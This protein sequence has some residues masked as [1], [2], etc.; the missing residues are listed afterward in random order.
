MIKTTIKQEA[1]VRKLKTASAFLLFF[2]LFLSPSSA[3]RAFAAPPTAAEMERELRKENEL[4]K[5]GEQ[6]EK[7]PIPPIDMALVKGGCYKMGDFIGE[8][9]DDERPVH[10]VCLTDFYMQTTEV[11]QDL[12]EAVMGY[13]PSKYKDPKKPVTGVSWHGATAFIKKLNEEKKGFYRLPTEAEW[14]YA[15]RSGGKDDMWAG[16]RNEGQLDDYAWFGD[17]SDGDL[18]QVKQ[19]KPNALGL[20]DMSG[21][22]WEWTEDY[23]DFDYYQVS[24]RKDPYGPDMS[25]WKVIR[26]GSYVEDPYKIRTTF[27]YAVESP[28]RLRNVGFR[29]AE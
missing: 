5:E 28:S 3:N 14:E 7:K 8:G 23:F 15:A 19:K 27:R 12:F 17:N 9:D 29:L 18:H 16:T 11:T 21:N 10:E 25:Y 2:S 26:G 24:P 1:V 22:A 13:N 4:I 6:Q 20:Y